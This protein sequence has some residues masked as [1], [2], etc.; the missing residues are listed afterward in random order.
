MNPNDI[1][2]RE[3]TPQDHK[4][5]IGIA[6]LAFGDEEE[7]TQLVDGLLTDNT[8]E[9][10]LSLLALCNDQPIGHILFTKAGFSEDTTQ[11]AM[12]ILAPLGV[13]PD[14]Q[15]KGVGGMLIKEGIQRLKQMGSKLVFVLGHDSYYPKFGFL[16][17]AALKGYPTP[18]P[19]PEEYGNCWMVLP[20]S[21]DGLNVGKGTVKTADT[22]NSPEHWSHDDAKE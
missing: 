1:V 12:H 14:F 17:Q 4:D 20:L 2:I 21:E 8:A 18:Y 6:K 13:A 9:P 3:T 22:L 7:V 10:K 11:P 16:P 15:R 19:I 5:I